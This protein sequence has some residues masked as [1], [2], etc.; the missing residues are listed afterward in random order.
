M[1][2]SYNQ[3]H[4]FCL[5]LCNRAKLGES[6]FEEFLSALRPLDPCKDTARLSLDTSSIP[7]SL[8]QVEA[9][10]SID[11]EIETADLLGWH[12]RAPKKRIDPSQLSDF[13]QIV[14]NRMVDL[15]KDSGYDTSVSEVIDFFQM[16]KEDGVPRLGHSKRHF[17]GVERPHL[18]GGHGSAEALETEEIPCGAKSHTI[19]SSLLRRFYGLR[20]GR[21]NRN[22]E[23]LPSIGAFGAC[24]QHRQYC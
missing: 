22:Q 3:F 5:A 4:R 18:P 12:L 21:V 6:V 7:F 11:Q 20:R 10:P 15:A 8:D 1:L 23:P 14:L 9:A 2:N 17:G 19:P 16:L 24:W 13:Q